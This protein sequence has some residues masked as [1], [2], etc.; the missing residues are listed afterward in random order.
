MRI[1]VVGAGSIGGYF[2]GRL[3]EARRDVTFLVRPG[4]AAKLAQTGLSIRSPLGDMHVPAP[5]TV[6]ADRLA[7]A[8]D[9]VLLSCKAYDL[10]GAMDSVAPAVGA[11][12]A[13]LPLLNG[14]RHL[15]LLE[16]RFG[17]GKVLGGQCLIS[18]VLDADGRILHLNDTHM[19]SFGERD[20]SRSARAQAVASVLSGARFDARLSEDILQEMWEKW[21]FIAASAGITC[22]MRAA[23]GD[24]VAADAAGLAITLLDECGAIAARNGHAPGDASIQRS[25]TML[26]A[27]GS[28]LTASMLRDIERGAPTEA[29]HILGD[30]LGRGGDK[31][32][33]SPVLRIAYAHLKAYEARR[34]REA[35][36]AKAA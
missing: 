3:L 19:L 10:E 33:H 15:D 12:T 21:V 34:A 32:D 7:G 9:L 1:L 36:I 13:I 31:A 16:A 27:A 4:R 20:G 24:I 6:T 17:A 28:R 22:L 8:F 35:A 14:M 25:R 5:P 23:V 2:G 11:D 18:T 29:R 30:L 26:T